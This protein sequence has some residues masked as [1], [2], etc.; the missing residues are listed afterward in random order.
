MGSPSDP[1]DADRADD[2]QPR[3][4]VVGL[5]RGIHGLRGA[6]RMEV[7]TDDPGRFEPG[8]RLFPEGQDQPLTVEWA[9]NDG[10]GILVRFRER[11]DR[12]SVEPLRDQYIEAL[13]SPTARPEGSWYWHEVVGAHVTTS[14]GEDL[15]AVTDVFRTGGSEVFV[16]DGHRGEVL[17]PAVGAVVVEFAPA[18]GRIVVDADALALDDVEPRSRVRGRRTTRARRDRER[19]IVGDA[20]AQGDASAGAPSGPGDV[21][22]SDLAAA[23]DE[24]DPAAP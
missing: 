20:P 1:S 19:G 9:Q 18:A 6:V 14:T 22:V 21:A 16:V 24:A 13:V 5:V 10:P 15:G 2:T 7:L 4:L 11:P 12:A 23:T 17:V 3:R 8:A